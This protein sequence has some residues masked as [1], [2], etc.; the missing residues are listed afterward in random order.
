M[1]RNNLSGKLH[2]LKLPF[3]KAYRKQKVNP[4]FDLFVN[5]RN[6]GSKGA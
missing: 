1:F 4:H 5:L 3:S 6:V 2:S